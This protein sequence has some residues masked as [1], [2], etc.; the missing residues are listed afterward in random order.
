MNMATKEYDRAYYQAHKAEAAKRNREYYLAHKDEIKA[1]RLMKEEGAETEEKRRAYLRAYYI[2]HR[3]EIRARQWV[4][5]HTY[6]SK[7]A[8]EKR[9]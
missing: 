2:S 4:Y 7:E 8:R 9:K 3:K 1:K 6:L 5:Y